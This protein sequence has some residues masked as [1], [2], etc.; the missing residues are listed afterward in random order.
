MGRERIGFIG[1]G[2][3]G[4]PVATR[5]LQAG[6]PLSFTS[7]KQSTVKHLESHGALGLPTPLLVADRSDILFTCLP[8]DSELFQ[9]FLG[10]DGVIEHLPEGAVIIDLSSAS[11]MMIQRIGD[12]ARVRNITVVDAPVSGGTYGA[13]HGT[14][15]ITVGATEDGFERVR[16]IL[17]HIGNDVAHVGGIGMGKIFKTV[18]NILTGTTM[19]MIGEVLALAANAGA[20]L[21]KLYETVGSSSGNSNVWQDVVPKLIRGDHDDHVGFRLELMRKDL[22][23]AGSLG[24]DLDTPLPLSTLARQFYTGAAARGLGSRHAYEIARVA[25]QTSGVEIRSPEQDENY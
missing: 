8:G 1:V 15:T 5:L 13:E 19:V 16:P 10:P 25:A 4:R 14:L 7:S 6:Y 3:M 11:P 24:D 17:D 20:D 21:E 18:N 9:V 2:S 23:L 22:N 12:E